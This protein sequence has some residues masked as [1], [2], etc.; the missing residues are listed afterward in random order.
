MKTLFQNVNNRIIT[1]L[2]TTA[3]ATEDNQV[4]DKV[5]TAC[6]DEAERIIS[7]IRLEISQ[8]KTSIDETFNIFP[9][10]SFQPFTTTFIDIF[11]HVGMS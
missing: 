3:H 8:L 10:D 11:A 6:K 4:E 7:K 9:I 5:N 1:F 2:N